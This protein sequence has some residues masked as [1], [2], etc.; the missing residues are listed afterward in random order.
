MPRTLEAK[1]R[2]MHNVT[3]TCGEIKSVCK[4]VEGEPRSVM[5]VFDG[6]GKAVKVA[7]GALWKEPKNPAKVRAAYLG[8][9][10]DDAEGGEQDEE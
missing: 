7:L 10:E 5:V 3:F 6:E 4:A 1:S 2:V 9:G 8:E